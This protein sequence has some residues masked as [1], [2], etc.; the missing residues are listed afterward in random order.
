ML[1][2][3][4]KETKNKEFFTPLESLVKVRRIGLL[5]TMVKVLQVH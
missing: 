1:G 3:I 2:E 4:F 5:K